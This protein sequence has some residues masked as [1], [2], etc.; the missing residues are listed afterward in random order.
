MGVDSTLARAY[1]AETARLVRQRLAIVA[2]LFVVLMGAGVAFEMIWNPDRSGTVLVFWAMESAVAVLALGL[3]RLPALARVVGAIGA[4]M[5]AGLATLITLYHV[6]TG[7]HG[8]RNA[9]TIG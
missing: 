7:A 1:A 6:V 4:L 9:M 8:E 2:P 5:T 3:S